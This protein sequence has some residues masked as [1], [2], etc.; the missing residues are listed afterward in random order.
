[1]Y[2]AQGNLSLT[3]FVKI[4][5]IPTSCFLHQETEILGSI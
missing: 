5:S 4:F 1:M 3:L 2:I